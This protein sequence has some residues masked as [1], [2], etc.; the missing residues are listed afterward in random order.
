MA[1]FRTAASK[2]TA[3]RIMTVVLEEDE[4]EE[5]EEEEA[6]EERIANH[7]NYGMC[8]AFYN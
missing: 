5:K 7:T 1:L 8:V 2:I 6:E 3:T 4:E